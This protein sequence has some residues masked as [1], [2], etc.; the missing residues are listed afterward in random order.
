MVSSS[1]APATA[2][3]LADFCDHLATELEL[4]VVVAPMTELDQLDSLQRIEVALVLRELGVI[5]PAGVW[6]SQRTVRDVYDLYALR[7]E[8]R[9]LQPVTTTPETWNSVVGALVSLRAIVPSDL[10]FL[11]A[12]TTDPRLIDRWRFRGAPPNP[13]DFYQ[14]LWQG[15]L[16]QYL[17]TRTDSGAP[18]GLVCAYDYHPSGRAYLAALEHP[19][20]IRSGLIL[21]GVALFLDYVFRRWDLHTLY[22][23]T[24][25][26]SFDDFAS[27]RLGL[28]ERV[29][30]LKQHH[31]Y[32]GRYQDLHVFRL[33]RSTWLDSGQRIRASIASSVRD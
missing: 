5:A 29:G 18:V 6:L 28:F 32:D 31:F 15:V 21:E 16:A 3:S 1:G 26:L 8:Q 19:E 14:L 17:V 23:E 10:D 4:D 20:L 7:A 24:L 22:I 25:D 9:D 12:L 27:N 13:D 33:Q 2:M 11:F 30:R